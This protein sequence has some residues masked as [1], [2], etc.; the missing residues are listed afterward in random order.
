M[1]STQFHRD[2]KSSGALL[3]LHRR[4]S[5]GQEFPDACAAVAL[6]FQVDHDELRQAY[7]DA[8]RELAAACC[9]IDRLC[10]E[11]EAAPVRGVEPLEGMLHLDIEVG[12]H[13]AVPSFSEVQARR[14]AS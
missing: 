10:G 4:V 3:D 13:A 14:V 6:R 2:A 5:A 12:D 11:R 7:D 1:P 9:D 8:C